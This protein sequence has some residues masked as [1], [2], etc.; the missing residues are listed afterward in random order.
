MGSFIHHLDR[1]SWAVLVQEIDRRRILLYLPKSIERK[2]HGM[3][4][5]GEVYEFVA[6]EEQ[7]AARRMFPRDAPEGIQCSLLH[8]RETFPVRHGY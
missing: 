6:A 1:K 5:N 3:A 8:I 7:R 2:P 4:E